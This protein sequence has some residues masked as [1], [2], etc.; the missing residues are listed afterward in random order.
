MTLDEAKKMKPGE[1]I[2]VHGFGGKLFF[3]GV[4]KNENGVVVFETE[5]DDIYHAELGKVERPLIYE[6]RW[7]H[8][9]K[10][11]IYVSKE[12]YSESE[13]NN[14]LSCCQRIDSTK[15][16]RGTE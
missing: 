13:A 10:D 9:G 2:L 6:W 1:Q 3:I 14:V 5:Q 16:L 7:V 8:C 15:R 4:T 12:F 11:N